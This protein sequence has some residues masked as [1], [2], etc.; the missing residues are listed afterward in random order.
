M[1]DA[2]HPK[3]VDAEDIDNDKIHTHDLTLEVNNIKDKLQSQT[4]KQQPEQIKFTQSRDPSNEAKP[5]YRKY[6]SYCYRTNHSISS[7]SKKYRDDDDKREAYAS[8]KSPQKVCVQYFQFN[9]NNKSNGT[10]DNIRDYYNRPRSRSTSRNN[11]YI[12]NNS[13]QRRFR[14]TSRDRN[15]LDRSTTRQYY[16]RSRYNYKQDSRSY[17]S[18]NGPKN[19]KPN[20][21]QV[22][23][24]NSLVH[25][26]AHT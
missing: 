21:Y 9:S 11:Y 1:L 6:C 12:E 2:R 19:G 16:T 14:S 4:I 3:L 10:D 20:Y 26:V 23:D 17:R 15:H 18:P 5:A 7:C 24:I 13:S 22:Y 8:S 25:N